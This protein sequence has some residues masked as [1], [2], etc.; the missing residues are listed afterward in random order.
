MKALLAETQANMKAE[1]G[2]MERRIKEDITR[3]EGRIDVLA[4]VLLAQ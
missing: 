4:N 2:A 1:M 3:L